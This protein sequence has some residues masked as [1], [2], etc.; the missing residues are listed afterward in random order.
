MLEV[1]VCLRGKSEREREKEMKFYERVPKISNGGLYRF[2]RLVPNR[3]KG[4]VCG[5]VY[6]AQ[7]ISW[8]MPRC[9][10]SKMTKLVVSLAL[11]VKQSKSMARR[12][13]VSVVL[14]ASNSPTFFSN[15]IFQ[16]ESKKHTVRHRRER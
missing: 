5:F 3:R 9:T 12:S 15:C 11:V 16:S 4:C 1:S 6:H 13:T 8:Q 14:C 2:S 10:H 7:T